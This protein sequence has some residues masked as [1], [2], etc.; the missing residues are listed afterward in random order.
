MFEKYKLPVIRL[1]KYRGCNEQHDDYSPHC[2]VVYRRVKRIDPKKSHH[3][4]K[5]FFLFIVSE[6]MDVN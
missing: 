3:K 4:E 2:R 5:L 6:I 1:N